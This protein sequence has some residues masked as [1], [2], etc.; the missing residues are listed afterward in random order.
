MFILQPQTNF[1]QIGESQFLINVPDANNVNHIAVFLTGTVPF[2]DGMAGA[3]K[4][5]Y[6]IL[7]QLKNMTQFNISVWQRN[8]K[9][10]QNY[11]LQC[12]SVGRI[13]MLHPIG[14]SLDF[15]PM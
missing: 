3:G 1:Q 8:R 15:S 2:P 4:R 12:T 14:N 7:L 6:F 10:R 9:F 5:S 13:R 11:C